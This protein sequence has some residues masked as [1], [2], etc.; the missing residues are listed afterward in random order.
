MDFDQ[1]SKGSVRLGSP[2]IGML[3]ISRPEASMG[4]LGKSALEATTTLSVCT[5]CE[6]PAV[7]A[8]STNAPTTRRAR[9]IPRIVKGRRD[10]RPPRLERAKAGSS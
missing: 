3:F 2:P 7:R 6:L 10:V 4:I 1:V 5:L 8:T 9:T